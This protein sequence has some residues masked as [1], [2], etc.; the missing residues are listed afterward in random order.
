M[1]LKT[2]TT[3]DKTLTRG[4]VQWAVKKNIDTAI[5]ISTANHSN[6]RKYS[7]K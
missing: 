2:M 7:L 3:Y 1:D 6:H 4:K 5:T